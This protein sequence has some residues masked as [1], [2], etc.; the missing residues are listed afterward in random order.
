M[1]KPFSVSPRRF[2]RRMPSRGF[3]I[4]SRLILGTMLI[5][6]TLPLMSTGALVGADDSQAAVPSQVSDGNI[7]IASSKLGT[8]QDSRFTYPPWGTQSW[9]VFDHFPNEFH[10]WCDAEKSPPSDGEGWDE[11]TPG[12]NDDKKCWAAA[13]SNV[14]EWTGWGYVVDNGL[15]YINSDDM[16]QEFIA[17]WTDYGGWA[18]GAWEWWIDG[19][20]DSDMKAEIQ[21]DGGGNFWPSYDPDGWIFVDKLSDGG[22]MAQALQKYL[23]L[24]YGVT[25]SI[26][27]ES[28]EES[29]HAITCW[30]F[31]YDPNYDAMGNPE[32]FYKGIWITDSDDDKDDPNP[33]DTL[34]YF[35]LVYDGWW[36]L[37]S[38]P[39]YSG[40]DDYYIDRV[41]ALQP[42][43]NNAPTA[44][45]G[46]P[47]TS[48]EG[49]EIAF[50]ANGSGDLDGNPLLYR[51]DYQ[52][53][54]IW[55]TDWQ[56]YAWGHHTYGDQG[57]YYA[58][59]AVS[60][61]MA[62]SYSTVAVTVNNVAPTMMEY[63][64]PLAVNEGSLVTFNVSA[65]DPGTDDLIFTLEISG[66]VFIKELPYEE[67]HG[68]GRF[69][70]PY[71]PGDN[72]IYTVNLTIADED[73][74]ENHY[75]TTL[76]VDDTKPIITP[77]GGSTVDEGSNVTLNADVWDFGSDD[78][79]FT[80]NF[81]LAPTIVNM[82]YNNGLS[83]DP[84][85]SPG[86]VFPFYAED[87]IVQPYGDD[88]FYTYILTVKD[89]EGVYATRMPSITVR[90]V[91]PTLSSY[92]MNQ[93]DP[94]FILPIVHTLTFTANA[95]DPGSDD[96]YFFW[97]WGD[98]TPDTENPHYFNGISPDPDRSPEKNSMTAAEWAHHAY[99]APGN[100]T[101]TLIVS[102][103][104][105]G[106]ATTTMAIHVADVA[107]ASSIIGQYIQSLPNTAFK[108]GAAKQK[109]AFDG[110]F[111]AV[112]KTLAAEQYKASITILKNIRSKTDGYMGGSRT[113][114]W[115]VQEAAQREIC[116]M[117]GD[118]TAYL[119]YL[120]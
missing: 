22:N 110:L 27:K 59:L 19:T 43:P 115:I 42:F 3:G 73:G 100:Y 81:D 46:G 57:T 35:D 89:D 14:L 84:P 28:D 77:F 54:G 87:M 79:E 76:F 85:D 53:D 2:F 62:V 41:D 118:L 120:L 71:T 31:Q 18:Y 72:G 60:D 9:L 96:L 45:I 1:D 65:A 44:S 49:S 101:V 112:G 58:K 21:L 93:P 114:D 16:F 70:F 5:C 7:N 15:K 66:Q 91:A 47:Y 99:A 104:D 52:N 92:S 102:D 105:G 20:V 109:A 30:G 117:I 111:Q 8:S 56:S 25:L 33:P 38:Y 55:D 95:T 39:L 24:G 6:L 29:G 17:H 51:F 36:H 113:D 48:D 90:N 80:W 50:N 34:Q 75:S 69:S 37:H 64:E 83:P 88:G 119:Q 106:I 13:A 94:N 74:G 103:D 108:S 11:I 61:R 116:H 4:A 26:R 12:A 23:N 107:E 86:G 40:S 63:F 68:S 97:D 32:L 82:H 67:V 78:L 98:G 10:S